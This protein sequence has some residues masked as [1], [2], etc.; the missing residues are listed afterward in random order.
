MEVM[1]INRGVC[2][3]INILSPQIPATR[4]PIQTLSTVAVAAVDSICCDI[5]VMAGGRTW[6]SG[7]T[8]S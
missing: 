4:H 7:S 5:L 1:L 6:N 3:K 2:H 8:V